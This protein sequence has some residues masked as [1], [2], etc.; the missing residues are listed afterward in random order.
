MVDD[1]SFVTVKGNEWQQQSNYESEDHSEDLLAKVLFFVVAGCQWVWCKFIQ[2]HQKH[3]EKTVFWPNLASVH[4]AKDKNWKRS[5]MADQKF[6]YQLEREGIKQQILSKK[7]KGLN[8]K[9]QKRA[10]VHCNYGNA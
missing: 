3:Q 1:E 10:E 9:Y 6:L 7:S 8:G 2:N 5:A 4:Y